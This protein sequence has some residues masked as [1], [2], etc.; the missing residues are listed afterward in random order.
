MSRCHNHRN[1]NETVNKDLNCYISQANKEEKEQS[2]WLVLF[3]LCMKDFGVSLKMK[4]STAAI[5]TQQHIL[6]IL[7]GQMKCFTYFPWQTHLEK[8]R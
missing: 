5:Q 6:F 2:N 4:I 7:T 3:P 8:I 1:K